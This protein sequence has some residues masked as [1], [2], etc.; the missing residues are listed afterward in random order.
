M[1]TYNEHLQHLYQ[2]GCTAASCSYRPPDGSPEK[3]RIA[4]RRAEVAQADRLAALERVAV[5]A[6]D[7]CSELT[8]DRLPGDG[9]QWREARALRDAL[10]ELDKIGGGS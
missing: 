6:R 2:D 4:A 10:A 8:T 7:L 1:T 3:A 5:A 9:T